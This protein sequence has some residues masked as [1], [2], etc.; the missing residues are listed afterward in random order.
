LVAAKGRL[1]GKMKIKI[2][3]FWLSK[4]G[5]LAPDSLHVNGERVIQP[6]DIL[7]AASKKFFN[8]KNA[9]TVIAFSVTREHSSVR[10]AEAFLIKHEAEIPDSGIIEVISYDGSGGEESAYIP[11]GF[12]KTTEA[13]YIGCSTFHS[14]TIIGGRITI[15][16]PTS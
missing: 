4:E 5:E 1:G 8:R 7:R 16:K 2:G 13:S 10:A 6:A 12:L 15:T 11:T 9:S 3:D 14:Y